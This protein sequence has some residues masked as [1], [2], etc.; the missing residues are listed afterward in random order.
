MTTTRLLSTLLLAL[1]LSACGASSAPAE[2]AVATTTPTGGGENSAPVEL[3]VRATPGARYETHTHARTESTD[4]LVLT[5]ARGS[6]QID[7][8]DTQTD[9]TRVTTRVHSIELRDAAGRPVQ[10][11]GTEAL[12]LSG[13]TFHRAIDSR[14]ATVGPVTV[15]GTNAQ[16]AAMA[17]SM[18]SMF[19]QSTIRL[20]ERPVRV[21]ESWRDTVQMRV[22]VQ[23]AIMPFACTT[24]SRLA[25]LDG[26]AAEQLAV[27]EFVS[28]CASEPVHIAGPAGELT[29]SIATHVT[30][31]SHVALAD[32]L[33]GR[34]TMDSDTRTTMRIG[35][36]PEAVIPARQHI[37]ITTTPIIQ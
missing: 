17:E 30:G 28:D 20:P 13:A 36:Q 31:E 1:A 15:E 33:A 4:G 25:R 37:E 5:D 21:G 22:P 19:E 6:M 8:V 7:G 9:V 23:G 34:I 24:D 29:F 14:A 16:N 3:R 11:A 27:I 12:D 35:D 10:A 32:G 18:R 26:S 2:P